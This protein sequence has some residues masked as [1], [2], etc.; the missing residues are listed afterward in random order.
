VIALLLYPSLIKQQNSV[1][2]ANGGESMGDDKIGPA[3]ENTL[4]GLLD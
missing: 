3:A 1:G 2:L 4:Q